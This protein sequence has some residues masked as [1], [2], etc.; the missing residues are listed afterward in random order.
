MHQI[1]KRKEVV[2]WLE[3]KL[4]KANGDRHNPKSVANFDVSEE[5]H[6]SVLSKDLILFL[7]RF[8]S[9]Y[10]NAR[11]WMANRQSRA[12][13]FAFQ[14]DFGGAAQS[15]QIS[16]M[17]PAAY[18]GNYEPFCPPYKSPQLFA[19]SCNAGFLTLN[20]VP[21]VSGVLELRRDEAVQAVQAGGRYAH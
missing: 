21:G 6:S 4:T 10:S 15:Q 9:A 7:R 3:P 2:V 17:H 19:S 16:Y 5:L 1:V 8:G 14:I 20:S 12:L 13:F 11:N 18:W